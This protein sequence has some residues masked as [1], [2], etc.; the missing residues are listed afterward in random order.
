[1]KAS[2]FWLSISM[3]SVAA[4]QSFEDLAKA[5]PANW[6]SYSG[7]FGAQRHWLLKKIN[8]ANI[9]TVA[10]KW[11]YHVAKAEELEGV[12]I[13]SNGVMYVS[14]ADEVNALDARTGRL[15]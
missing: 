4:G 10:P 8:T 3:V 5:D 6:L 11:I 7:S 9:T 2:L 15:I 13:V 12:P 1:M 14:Q